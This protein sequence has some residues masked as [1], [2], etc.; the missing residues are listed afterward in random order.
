VYLALYARFVVCVPVLVIAAGLAR[1][2]AIM[3]MTVGS[4][5]DGCGIGGAIQRLYSAWIS[6]STT[7]WATLFA[8]PAQTPYRLA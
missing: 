1:T 5:R 3:S 2:L 8:V 4:R 7:L 6:P